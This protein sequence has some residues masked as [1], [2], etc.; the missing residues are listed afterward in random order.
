[1]KLRP[2]LDKKEIEY[3]VG[4]LDQSNNPY[5]FEISSKLKQILLKASVGLVKPTYVRQ[6]QTVE[7]KLGIENKKTDVREIAYNKFS[8]DPSLC[9]AE[10]ISQAK[11][12]AYSNDLMT[13]EE[14]AEYERQ[15][16]EGL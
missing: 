14:S 9:T 8:I 5:S 1:M 11:E 10:E 6:T 12:Y 2:Y 16:F 4:L 15:F 13:E 7:E 3:I